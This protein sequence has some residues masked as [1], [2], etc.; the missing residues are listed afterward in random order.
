MAD[1]KKILK[2][3]A[4]RTIIALGVVVRLCAVVVA[5][6]CVFW[7]MIFLADRMPR[8]VDSAENGEYT[9]ILQALGSPGW[10][11]GPQDGRV[12]LKKDGKTICRKNFTLHNDGK[13]MGAWNWEVEWESGRVLVTISGEEQEDETLALEYQ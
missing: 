12:V 10:P 6:G 13:N 4:W 7:N 5:A 2:R 3:A 8:T 9:V 1:S 11:F